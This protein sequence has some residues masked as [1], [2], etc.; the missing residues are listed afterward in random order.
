[1][2]DIRKILEKI[3]SMASA[4]KNPTGPKFPGYWKGTDSAEKAKSKMVGGCEESFLK[5]LHSTAKKKVTEWSLEEAYQKFKEVDLGPTSPEV[6]KM[7]TADVNKQIGDLAKSS[8]AYTGIDPIVR[9]RMGM[10]P[11]SQDEIRSYLDAN[12]PVVRSGSGA[13]VTS[14]S[15]QAVQSGGQ[16][17]V[18]KAADAVSPDRENSVAREPVAAPVVA[19]PAPVNTAP[20]TNPD[21]VVNPVPNRPNLSTT[22]TPAQP[23]K[24]AAVKPSIPTMPKK[25][26]PGSWQ[27][28]WKN[29]PGLKNPNLIRPGQQIKLPDGSFAT[30]DKGDTLS[31]IAKRY[32]QG[33]YSDGT[34]VDENNKNEKIAGRYSPDEFDQL[35]LKVKQKAQDQERK[36]GPVD[37]AKLAQ[38]LRDIDRKEPTKEQEDPAVNKQDPDSQTTSQTSPQ[39]DPTAV[40]QQQLDQQV[41]VATAKGT[42]SGLK[43]VLGPKVDTNALSSAVTKI[44]DQKPLTGPESQ[45]MS[46]LTPLISKAAETPQTAMALKTALS[47]AALLAKQGK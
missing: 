2:S 31:S 37:I 11:A 40:R 6:A 13:P 14:R 43:P 34:P 18:A 4:K 27:D 17:N 16:V 32:R 35:V 21:V 44:S 25:V 42:M 23:V 28:I 20:T 5:D 38:R 26:S 39:Q 46:A 19:Q 7:S 36:H 12:P 8:P 15:G 47:N 29:N 10:Q 41:D 1:M 30:V 45:A 22:S 24:P 9:Q 33:G 3:D